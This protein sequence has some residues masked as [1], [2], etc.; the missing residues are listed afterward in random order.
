MD[1][2][3][4]FVFD[5]KLINKATRRC[6]K[7]TLIADYY[8]DLSEKYTGCDWTCD[9]DGVVNHRVDPYSFKEHGERVDNCYRYWNVD[10]YKQQNIKD[11]KRI[12]LCG[13]K[14]CN[15]CQNLLSK[16]RYQKY[17]PFLDLIAQS[18]YL[19]HI[20][21]TVP[22]VSDVQFKQTFN[23]MYEKFSYMIKYFTGL[24]KI[25]GIDFPSGYVGAVRSVEITT[26]T[27]KKETFYHPHFHCIFVF[28]KPLPDKGKNKNSFSFDKYGRRVTRT[29]TDFEILLQKVWYLLYNDERCILSNI[30]ELKEGYS[31]TIDDLKKHPKG[32]KEVFKYA[33]GGLY[34]KSGEPLKDFTLAVFEKLYFALYNRKIIQGYGILNKFKF[35]ND[36][37]LLQDEIDMQYLDLQLLLMT[38]E[39]PVNY[40][41]TLYNINLETSDP[42]N[43]TIYISRKTVKFTLEE[44]ASKGFVLEPSDRYVKD[45]KKE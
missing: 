4:S 40:N 26:Q 43:P 11:I 29:F 22:N 41:D 13:D 45:T 24:K 15:N 8:M 23:R 34:K 37:S 38:I 7:N 1:T 16:R 30:N 27:I 17:K 21:F 18:K 25:K 10:Y 35:D 31:V 20:V 9:E 39:K 42:N 14:F 5:K 3:K 2:V 32:Y 12:S 33:I 6:R 28:D 44:L 36:D 19:Y